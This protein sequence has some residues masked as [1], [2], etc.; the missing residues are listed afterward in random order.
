M[1]KFDRRVINDLND[2]LTCLFVDGAASTGLAKR[3]LTKRQLTASRSN[4]DLEFEN[5]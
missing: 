1:L 2:L 4:G 3:R 5:D